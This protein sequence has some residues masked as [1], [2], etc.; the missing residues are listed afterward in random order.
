MIRLEHFNKIIYFS[1]SNNLFIKREEKEREK[2][3]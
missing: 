1:K 2:E 3:K